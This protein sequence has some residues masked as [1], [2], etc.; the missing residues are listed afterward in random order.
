MDS[1]ARCIE[2]GA[3]D[4]LCKPFNP[5][6]LKARIG[7]SLDKKRGRDREVELFQHLDENYRRLQQLETLRDDLTHMIIH[8]LRTPLTS[9]MAAMQTM[10]VV[11]EVNAAQREV[12]TIAVNGADS[13]LATINSL[14]DVE[15]LEAGAM[16]LDLTLLSLPEVIESV[17]AQVRALAEAKNVKLVQQLAAD[18]SWL[19][20][21]EGK[22]SRTLVNLLGNAIKFTPPGGSVT[23]E[24]GPSDQSV[25]FC[26]RDT[27]GG[28]PAEQLERIF[29]KFAQVESREG[30]RQIGSGLGL[31]FCK[32]AVEAHGGLIG[33]ESTP[34]LGSAFSFSIPLTGG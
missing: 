29:E 4:Y 11:G 3:D 2:M 7:A 6:L 20:A 33:V 34:G 31:T 22:L 30:G 25:R 15:Q 23:L 17:L 27:G 32:L 12:M 16:K 9:V 8:D 10:D 21:D 24:V 1:V 19:Q 14:L 13:L 28:I 18:L 26:V 5:I